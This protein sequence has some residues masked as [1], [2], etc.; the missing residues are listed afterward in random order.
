M[1]V[2]QDVLATGL[3]VIGVSIAVYLSTYELALYVLFPALLLIFSIVLQ[4]YVLKKMDY[5]NHVTNPETVV[6]IGYYTFLGLVGLLIGNLL[7][8]YFSYPS[9]IE[10]QAL[11]IMSLR[12]FV[13]LMAIAE[14]QFFRGFL[15]NLFLALNIPAPAAIF[16]SALMFAIYHLRVY[17]TSYDALLYVF[18]AGY[19]LGYIAYMSQRLSPCMLAHIMNNLIAVGL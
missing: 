11:S 8:P 14:E 19:M 18:A 6:N 15:L 9:T 7:I 16:T 10:N 13:T 5:V 12:L 2:K 4:L 3:T 1:Y 17:G